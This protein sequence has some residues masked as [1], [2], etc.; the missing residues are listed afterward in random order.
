[1]GAD[2]GVFAFRRAISTETDGEEAW[3]VK[4]RPTRRD[5]LH[6]HTVASV[7]TKLLTR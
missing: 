4:A 6:P 5:S 7:Y 1:M 3:F 2:T